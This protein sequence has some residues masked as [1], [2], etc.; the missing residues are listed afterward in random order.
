MR[1]T[2]AFAGLA[3]GIAFAAAAATGGSAAAA[4]AAPLTP[5]LQRA[6]DYTRHYEERFA[7]IIGDE[8]YEQRVNSRRITVRAPGTSRQK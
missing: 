3:C 2:L 4:Q 1:L 5:L 8:E 7:V 6:A